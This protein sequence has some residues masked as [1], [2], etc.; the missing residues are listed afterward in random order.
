MVQVDAKDTHPDCDS[1]ASDTTGGDRKIVFFAGTE[2]EAPT[3]WAPDAK[4]WLIG[5]DPD[6]GED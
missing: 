5:Q 2:G 4:S 3:L 6:D 1:G